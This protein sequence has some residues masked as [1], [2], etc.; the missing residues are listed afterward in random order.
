VVKWEWFS[1]KAEDFSAAAAVSNSGGEPGGP[2]CFLYQSAS[3]GAI[4]SVPAGIRM[5]EPT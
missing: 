2:H 4:P 3:I 5:V 1:K